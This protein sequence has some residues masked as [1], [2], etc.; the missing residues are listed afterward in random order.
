MNF[1]KALGATI[2]SFILFLSLGLFSTLFLLNSTLLNPDF[3]VNQVGKLPVASLIRETAEEQFNQQLPEEAW[4]LK[5]TMY[6]VIS[7]QEPWIKEQVRNGIYSFYD[8][9][10]GKSE[11]LSMVISLEELKEGLRDSLW[12]VFQQNI[13]PEL[14]GLPPAMIDQYFE[15]FYRQFAGQ[16]PSEIRLDESQIPP[17]VMAYLVQARQYI[18]YTQ[19]AYYALIGLMVLLV[20]GIILISRN[21]RGATRGLGTTFLIYGALEYAGIWATNYFG[22]MY[23]PMME[24]PS[25]LQAWLLQFTKDF[26]APLEMFS[27]GLLAA[28]VVLLVVSF[29]YKPRRAEEIEEEVM[30]EEVGE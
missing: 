15:E 25:S 20:A 10:L 8:F 17:E 28:G 7:D 9:L 19:T 24:I 22:P 14:A 1:L 18:S 29:V 26:M 27:I 21:V 13:P 4:F 12:E 30:E 11:R 3:M 5:E 6:N 16:I 23:L 2:L